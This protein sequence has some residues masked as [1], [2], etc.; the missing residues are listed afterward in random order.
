MTGTTE[1]ATPPK[2]PA[3]RAVSFGDISAALRAGFSD[4]A[5]APLFGLFFG[6]VFAAGGTLRSQPATCKRQ[7]ID[8]A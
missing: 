7:A 6:G 3:V 4:F 2:M 5:R 8:L 1:A